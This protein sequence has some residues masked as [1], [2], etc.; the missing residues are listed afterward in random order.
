MSFVVVGEVGILNVVFIEAHSLVPSLARLLL[1]SE[2][3]DGAF[4]CGF[5]RQTV[6]HSNLS[7]LKRC[8]L[9][10][11]DVG[12]HPALFAQA[13][14]QFFHRC[15]VS[16]DGVVFIAV[17]DDCYKHLVLLAFAFFK[18]GDRCAYGIV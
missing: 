6:F 18:V 15:A 4:N 1:E 2:H 3:I 5:K 9:V 8:I 11:T 12:E 16:L 13:V 17:G 14:N 10:C 7:S